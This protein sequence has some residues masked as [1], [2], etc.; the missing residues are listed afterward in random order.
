[1]TESVKCMRRD[2][3]KEVALGRRRGAR[4]IMSQAVEEDIAR[5]N[6]RQAVRVRDL[7]RTRCLRNDTGEPLES[8]WSAQGLLQ[9]E[10]DVAQEK[11]N[12]EAWRTNQG[13]KFPI[14]VKRGPGL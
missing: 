14:A 4:T 6:W 12:G 13:T 1:M 8:R 2:N 9:N 11:Q 7:I 10:T 5:R 3:G